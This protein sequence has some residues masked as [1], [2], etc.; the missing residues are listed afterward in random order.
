[1]SRF[2]AKPPRVKFG[3]WDDF[4]FGKCHLLALFGLVI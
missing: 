3:G 1:M 4:G 2:G